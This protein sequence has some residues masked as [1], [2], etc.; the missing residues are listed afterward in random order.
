M[1]SKIDNGSDKRESAGR[2]GKFQPDRS[3]AADLGDV[4]TVEHHTSLI[5]GVNACDDV[6]ER[7]LAGT[8]GT[9][10]A[11]D[12]VRRDGEIE[13]VER[14]HAA[15]ALHQAAGFEQRGHGCHPGK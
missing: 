2:C 7:G 6:E 9:D 5:G 1:L 8:V 12:F 10:Q 4:D 11:D 15:E 14:D 3:C 13:P